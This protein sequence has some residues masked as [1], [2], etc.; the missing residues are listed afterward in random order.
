LT[1]AN[2]YVVSRVTTEY[3]AKSGAP[4]SSPPVAAFDDSFDESFYRPMPDGGSERGASTSPWVSPI[5]AS[6]LGGQS[7][8]KAIAGDGRSP[9]P[10]KFECEYL[11]VFAPL[12]S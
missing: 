11:I 1:V 10:L 6:G 7:T 12:G 3:L 4:P 8:P 9:S 5:K 2:I